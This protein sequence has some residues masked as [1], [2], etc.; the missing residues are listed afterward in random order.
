MTSTRDLQSI[1]EAIEEVDHQIL[2]HLRKRMDLVE[3]VVGAKL[4]S[5]YPFRDESRE[6]QILQRVRHFAV[7]EGLDAREVERLYRVILEMS[8]AHQRAHVRSLSTAPL[9]VS[10]QGVEGAY[11]HLTAQ[12]RYAGLP[13]GVLLEGH[14]TFRG[15][16]DAVRSGASDRALLPIENTTAGSINETYDLLAEGGLTITAE[17]VSRIEHCLLGLPGARIE[18]LHTILSHPQGLAQCQDFLRTLPGVRTHAEFDTAGSARKV[19]ERN[20]PGVAAIA[21]E[22]AAR[23]FGLEVL[24]RG[25]QSQEGNYTRFVELAREPEPVP[26]GTPAQTSLLLAVSHQPGALAS[27][28]G[29]FAARGINVTKLESR[30]VPS[31]PWQYRFYLDLEGHAADDP[32]R[33]ALDEARSLT[34]ELRVLGTYPAAER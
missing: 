30:P 23:I 19:R 11:S 9:R 6:E 12:R 29:L 16:A 21:S 27:L 24:R 7:E 25:I 20:D 4:E 34:T 14:E 28:L 17:V 32:I 2:A 33:T 3:Q 10:Y 26:A 13:G 22:P 8:V 1:R 15:A 18:D 31:T 5:A